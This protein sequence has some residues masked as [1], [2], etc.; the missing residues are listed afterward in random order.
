[1]LGWWSIPGRALTSLG[2]LG[3]DFDN[4]DESTWILHPYEAVFFHPNLQSLT[5]TG[6]C[7]QTVWSRLTG[8]P[9]ARSTRLEELRLLNCDLSPRDLSEML[10]YPRALKHFT[11]KGQSA[12]P[13][14]TGFVREANRSAYIDA[15]KTHASSLESMDLDLYF[16]WPEPI[17]LTEF[18]ALKKLTISRRMLVGDGNESQSPG[19]YLPSTFDSEGLTFRADYDSANVIMPENQS[20]PCSCWTYRHRLEGPV[21]GSTTFP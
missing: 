15:L 8:A 16:P 9:A 7:V 13:I 20:C 4:Y 14:V 17:D 10:S 11:F 12:D 6:A 1:M 2:Q 21:G 5:I 19:K 18:K 3:F